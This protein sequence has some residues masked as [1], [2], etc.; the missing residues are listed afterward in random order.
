MSRSP[1]GFTATLAGNYEA[2][3]QRV[4]SWTTLAAQLRYKGADDSWLHGLT[5]TVVPVSFAGGFGTS[6]YDLGARGGF[7]MART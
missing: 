1:G 6:G 7:V 3:T 5:L 4:G 2:E